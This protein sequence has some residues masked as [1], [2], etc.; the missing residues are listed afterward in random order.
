[1]TRNHTFA[2]G[3]LLFA[4]AWFLP[5]HEYGKALPEK[6]PGWEALRV[7]LSPEWHKEDL[8]HSY[9]A[10][11][12]VASALTNLLVVILV[13]AWRTRSE[14]LV[15]FLGWACVISLGLNAQWFLNNG[16]ELR[17]GYYLW[18]LSF[19]VLGLACLRPARKPAAP[20]IDP[21]L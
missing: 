16:S 4:I 17:L 19:G 15:Q 12:S 6:L 1:M 11:L 14:R 7:A 2:V 21:A 8:A 13:F 5:V 10:A 3:M 9:A 20:N 18:W